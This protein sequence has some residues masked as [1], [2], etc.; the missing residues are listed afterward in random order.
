MTRKRET[1][2]RVWQSPS[3]EECAIDILKE[4]GKP[5]HYKEILGRVLEKRPVGGETPHKTAYA[6]LIRSKHVVRIQKGGIFDLV[7]RVAQNT[8][9]Q[10]TKSNV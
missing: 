6:T 2:P 5:L 9:V 8:S 10:D 7:E 1:S 3:F 4:A